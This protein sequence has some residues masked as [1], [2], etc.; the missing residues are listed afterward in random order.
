MKKSAFPLGVSL[1][2][3]CC[4]LLSC[5]RGNSRTAESPT[6]H[7]GREDETLNQIAR[8]ARENFPDFIGTM[9][10]PGPDEGNFRVKY[11]F[12]AEPGSA[13]NNE[14]VWL[15]NIFFEDGRYYGTVANRP[16]YLGSLQKGDLAAFEEGAISDWM[17][18]RTGK[19]IG[20]RSIKYLIEQ[21]PEPDRDDESRAL[22]R[23]FDPD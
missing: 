10:N 18:I 7:I 2:I 12:T 13:F 20:G 22:Y 5:E 19:I 1:C 9:Q 4:C 11:P 21:I 6:L 14:Y 23:M 16:Y 17:Y 8:E 3:L 15:E